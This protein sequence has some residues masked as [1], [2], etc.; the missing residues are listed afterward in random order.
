M[1]VCGLKVLEY[2][3]MLEEVIENSGSVPLTGKR[4]L[5]PDK[6]LDIIDGL[7]EVLPTEFRQ[8][9]ILKQER[10]RILQ[11]AQKEA[12]NIV[13]ETEN[14]MKVLVSEH[15][16]TQKANQR[17]QEII[18]HSE[19]SAKEIR[20]GAISYADDLLNDLENYMRQYHSVIDEYINVVAGNRKKLKST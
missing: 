14:R 13:A 11:D 1:G 6:L 17:A 10:E 15:E 19:A 18:N 16:I 3:D 12:A 4:M 8:A 5:D 2:L 9:E 20:E 7:R